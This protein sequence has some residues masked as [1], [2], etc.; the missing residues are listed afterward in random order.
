MRVLGTGADRLKCVGRTVAYARRICGYFLRTRGRLASAKHSARLQETVAALLHRHADTARPAVRGVRRSGRESPGKC[1]NKSVRCARE[2]AAR[3]QREVSPE[4]P[5]GL[6][7][8]ES[9]SAEG[10]C[11]E[12]TRPARWQ[13]ADGQV[14]LRRGA[15][16]RAGL[17]G[18]AFAGTRIQCAGAGA[19][20]RF[21]GG[22][23]VLRPG[24]QA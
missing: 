19:A 24:H 16:G 10:H 21:F 12:G 7:L 6:C 8:P 13:C 14:P 23:F 1:G 22:G 4:A 2:R 17:S 3:V 20:R 18:A 11:A 5:G 15:A 9:H